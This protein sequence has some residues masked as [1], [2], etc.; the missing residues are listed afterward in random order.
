MYLESLEK[1]NLSKKINEIR[2]KNIQKEERELKQI[3]NQLIK[4]DNEIN[5]LNDEIVKSLDGNSVFTPEQLSMAI[6]QKHKA[7]D[8][9]SNRKSV[10]N[11]ILKEKMSEIEKFIKLQNMI[12]EWADEFDRAP[13]DIK[14]MMASELL[15]EV[16]IF[17]DRIEVNFKI[18][19][20]DFVSVSDIYTS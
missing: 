2:Q 16:V 11:E 17:K 1:I 5:K 9:L 13:T 7:K 10:L 3:D 14:K 15:Q 19:F 6:T 18:E 20:D 8:D 4:I 12:P